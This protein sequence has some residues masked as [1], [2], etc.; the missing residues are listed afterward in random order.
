MAQQPF[1]LL[2]RGI[3]LDAGRETHILPLINLNN[4]DKRLLAQGVTINTI[5]PSMLNIIIK[6]HLINNYVSQYVYE[7]NNN[8]CVYLNTI[9][10][11]KIKELSYAK[12]I[13]ST[14]QKMRKNAGLHPWNPINLGY[15]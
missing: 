2:A 4:D 7:N 9:I 10:T 8:Y 6:P 12:F 11:D 13:G 14:F 15:T 1:T 5:E 3:I